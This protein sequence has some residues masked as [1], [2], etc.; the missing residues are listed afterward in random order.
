MYLDE[1][2]EWRLP[3]LRGVCLA[4]LLAAD[5]SI[6]DAEGYDPVTQL[7][8]VRQPALRMPAH[9][10]RHDAQVALRQLRY[11]FRTF[12][13]ADAHC[14]M[15]RDLG[16]EVV[17]LDRPPG[18]DESGF[19]IGLLTAVARPSLSLAPGLLLSAPA[20]SGAGT[21]KG[22]L[23]R[24]ICSIAYGLKP[25][26]FTGGGDRQ[27]LEKR[28]A[29]D[30][31]AAESCVYLDNVNGSTLRSN[32][33]AQ[34]LT[35]PACR[36]R[37]L[38]HSR[39]MSLSPSTFVVVTGNGVTLSEDLTRRFVVCQLDARCEHAEQRGFAPG[40]I[41]DIEQHRGELLAAALTIWRW[42]RLNPAD[43]PHGRPFGS[44]EDWAV[45]CRDPLVVLG[46]R[47]PVERIEE[48]RSMDP[49]RIAN[50]ELYEVWWRHHRDRPVKAADL[51]TDVL[52][53]IDPHR[54]G[55]QHVVAYLTSLVGT[56]LAGF[57][58]TRARAVGRW[59]AATY[60]LQQ[61]HPLGASGP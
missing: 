22:L 29:A 58:L 44:Y 38:G 10:Q 5:G 27:E 28:L 18:R 41:R 47:D 16:V 24:A 59:G 43:I 26:A 55:R 32:F 6:R 45:W 54:R 4:P 7:W 37:L 56:R 40:F 20:I 60:A 61:T 46:C 13:F 15:D 19:L 21:G 14:I 51:H 35:E 17:D 11:G 25:H 1:K 34:V 50:A 39:M 53:R 2:G 33:L 48:L 49:E 9:P 42:A 23:T 3:T 12:P 52:A 30:L 8:C 31:I 57:V 36:F